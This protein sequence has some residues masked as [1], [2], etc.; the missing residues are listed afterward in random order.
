MTQLLTW[1]VH[2]MCRAETYVHLDPLLDGVGDSLQYTIVK[3]I[4]SIIS[5]S[6][7][8]SSSRSSSIV[9]IIIIFSI[10]IRLNKHAVTHTVPLHYTD[11]HVSRKT[12]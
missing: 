1:Y 6:S 2:I 5:S 3:P 11:R 10:I 4:I 9:I 12:L 8:S 7:S